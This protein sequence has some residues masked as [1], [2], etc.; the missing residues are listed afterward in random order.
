[1]RASM[2]VRVECR[3]RVTSL[4]RTTDNESNSSVQTII[5]LYQQPGVAAWDTVAPGRLDAPGN[6][7]ALTLL[8]PERQRR[9]IGLSRRVRWVGVKRNV[10]GAVAPGSQSGRGGAR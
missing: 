1:M 9:L 3:R 6:R 10:Y 5:Y 8:D 7:S 2:H 4:N